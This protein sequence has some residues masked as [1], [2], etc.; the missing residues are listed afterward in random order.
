MD[1]LSLRYAYMRSFLPDLQYFSH[2]QRL[3]TAKGT[4]EPAP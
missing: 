3:G 1:S 4:E 2:F